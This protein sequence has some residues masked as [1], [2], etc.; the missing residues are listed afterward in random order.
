MVP[1]KSM[2]RLPVIEDTDLQAST[3]SQCY[4]NSSTLPQPS[5]Q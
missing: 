5:M 2:H 1:S 4:I 3:D